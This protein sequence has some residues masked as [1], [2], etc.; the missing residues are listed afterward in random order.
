MKVSLP[1]DAAQAVAANVE[2]TRRLEGFIVRLMTESKTKGKPITVEM[3]QAILGKKINRAP[4]SRV[5]IR[6]LDLVK[7]VAE[8]F[9]LTLKD[10]RGPRRVRPI[11]VPRQV[12]MYLLRNDMQLSLVE[13]GSLFGGRDHTTVMH[14]VDKIS[15]AAAESDSLRVDLT[16]LRK[17]I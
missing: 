3:V 16:N 15:K 14:A 6:P 1:M 13:I 17:G 5:T 7:Q 12:A 9:H 10:M 8:Y 4:I 2:S 11:V